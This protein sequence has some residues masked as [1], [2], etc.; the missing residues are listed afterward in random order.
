MRGETLFSKSI[1]PSVKSNDSKKSFA[2]T[3]PSKINETAVAAKP[4]SLTTQFYDIGVQGDTK[5]VIVQQEE[6]KVETLIRNKHWTK[7]NWELKF[8][9]RFRPEYEIN[10]LTLVALVNCTIAYFVVN[11]V[12]AWCLY[13]F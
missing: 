12:V 4:K 2:K 6:T 8:F 1:N 11:V 13:L 10:T 3:L 9:G 5:P 7:Q